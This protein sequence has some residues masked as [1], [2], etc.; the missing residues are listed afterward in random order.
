MT[1]KTNEHDAVLA[2]RMPKQMLAQLNQLSRLKMMPT[3]VM[4]RIALAEYMQ[5]EA[6]NTLLTP[7]ARQQ[8]TQ[9]KP[10]QKSV[11]RPSEQRERDWWDTPEYRAEQ[12]RLLKEARASRGEDLNDD[13]D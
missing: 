12:E 2:V 9:A 5:Q 8:A 1:Q 13:W 11:S 6:P 10:I 7:I 4:V 3:A